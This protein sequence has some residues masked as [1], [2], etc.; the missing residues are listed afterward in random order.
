MADSCDSQDPL[1]IIPSEKNPANRL[2]L[3]LRKQFPHPDFYQA[4]KDL[5]HLDLA[6]SFPDK[7]SDI[8]GISARFKAFIASL[9]ENEEA[10]KDVDALLETVDKA[11]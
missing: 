7:V 9:S 1:D 11:K 5:E 2:M 4:I 8:A 10:L 6:R 3:T